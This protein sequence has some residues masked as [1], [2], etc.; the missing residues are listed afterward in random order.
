M[1]REE[2][3]EHFLDRGELLLL[4]DGAIYFI[5]PYCKIHYITMEDTIHPQKYW[6][7]EIIN[8]RQ[9]DEFWTLLGKTTKLMD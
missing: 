8:A 1:S 6:N 3:Q 5:E 9:G 4:V 2:F 7:I